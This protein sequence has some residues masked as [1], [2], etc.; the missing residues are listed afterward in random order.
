MYMHLS[1]GKSPN[2]FAAHVDPAVNSSTFFDPQSK[3]ES[4]LDEKERLTLMLRA[5]DNATIFN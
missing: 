3:E 5:E 1:V 4:C 2:V